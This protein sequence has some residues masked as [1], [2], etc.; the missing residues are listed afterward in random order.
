MDT[1]LLRTVGL[2][3]GISC[4]L[5]FFIAMPLKYFFDM[6]QFVPYVGLTH[7]I[8]FLSFLVV[9]LTTCH[10]MKWSILIF[11]IGLFAAII[12]IGTFIFDMKI[13]KMSG[14]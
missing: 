2:A 3:E 4:I 7:G 12:P 9:L 14:E 8:L 1:Q 13:K 11:V 10:K 6:P 5:L